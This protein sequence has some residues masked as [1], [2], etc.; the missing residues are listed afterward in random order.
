M[1]ENKKKG[2]IALA[3]EF[4][5]ALGLSVLSTYDRLRIGLIV[6]FYETYKDRKDELREVFNKPLKEA[7]EFLTVYVTDEELGFDRRH[8]LETEEYFEELRKSPQLLDKYYSNE[9]PKPK[10]FI[11]IYKFS[12]YEKDPYGEKGFHVVTFNEF[13]I[14]YIFPEKNFALLDLDLREKIANESPCAAII[15][16]EACRYKFRFDSA[17]KFFDMDEKKVRMKFG[18]DRYVKKDNPDDKNETYEFKS[19]GYTKSSDIYNK[20]LK[21][22]V[23]D[24]LKR[25]YCN[26]EIP[27]FIEI[28]KV[29][30]RRRKTRPDSSR[31]AGRPKNYTIPK[32]RFWV[33][34]HEIQNADAV[35]IKEDSIPNEYDN[36]HEIYLFRIVLGEI[37][38][39]NGCDDKTATEFSQKIAD[40]VRERSV[41]DPELP[42]KCR[43]KIENLPIKY[44]G[45]D[46]H[47]VFKLIQKVL[48]DYKQIGEDIS[49]EKAKKAMDKKTVMPDLFWPSDVDGQINVLRHNHQH[50]I[51]IMKIFGVDQKLFEKVMEDFNNRLC[52]PDKRNKKAMKSEQEAWSY[53]ENWLRR[54]ASNYD[55][56]VDVDVVEGS[57]ETSQGSNRDWLEVWNNC[58]QAATND[59]DGNLSLAFQLMFFISFDENKKSLS[60]RVTDLIVREYVLRYAKY[61]FYAYVIKFFGEGV[62]YEFDGRYNAGS[63]TALVKFREIY[64][65]IKDIHDKSAVKWKDCQSE[66]AVVDRAVF[67]NVS[68]V[69]YNESDK[70]LM[71]Q[72][73]DRLVYDKIEAKYVSYLRD[74]LRRY[75]GNNTKLTYMINKN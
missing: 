65:H 37:L 2:E 73:K 26:Q 70:D 39:V 75:Y 22:K 71:I 19:K 1:E 68:F 59:R 69:S 10:D 72:V 56:T 41:N 27:F 17:K 46:V 42:L 49:S 63:Q 3:V 21:E 55:N 18:F 60:I 45:K 67:E 48:W 16:E 28:E 6:K 5:G 23:E 9:N 8:P 24:V 62:K 54:S 14:N 64:D 32:Y 40:Q 53:F 66:L 35:E 74:V 50:V 36:N 38:R 43:K 25:F 20:I 51:E 4:L 44:D 7:N 52:Q 15:Y 12:H 31:T 47:D 61:R 30:P 29:L 57:A 58:S 33:R 13:W 11:P 34:F